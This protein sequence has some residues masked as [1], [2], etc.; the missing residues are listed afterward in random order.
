MQTHPT[1]QTIRIYRLCIKVTYKSC[2]IKLEG[3]RS[4]IDKTTRAGSADDNHICD[5]EL[6]PFN[7]LVI[8]QCI[9]RDTMQEYFWC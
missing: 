2:N 7:L 6:R 8:G 5:L 1:L 9:P 4:R 3:L